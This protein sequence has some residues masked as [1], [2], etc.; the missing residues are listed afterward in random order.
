M[1]ISS[2][3]IYF[4]APCNIASFL[5]CTTRPKYVIFCGGERLLNGGKMSQLSKLGSGRE[6]FCHTFDKKDMPIFPLF[7]FCALDLEG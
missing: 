1:V 4:D 3:I 6:A 5:V 7:L 2:K